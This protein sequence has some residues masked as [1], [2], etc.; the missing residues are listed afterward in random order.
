MLLSCPICASRNLIA[1]DEQHPTA[2]CNDCSVGFQVYLPDDPGELYKHVNYDAH[3]KANA[4]NVLPHSAW[5]RF[6]HDRTVGQLRYNQLEAVLPLEAA[7]DH[8]GWLDFGCGAGGVLDVVRNY[9]YSV[10]GVELDHAFCAEITHHL[11]I[12]T[13]TTSQFLTHPAN[14]PACVLSLFDVLEHLVSPGTWLKVAAECLTH[15]GNGLI[16]LEVPDFGTHVGPISE[17]KHFRPNEHL[18][19]FSSKSL[20]CMRKRYFKNFKLVHEIRPVPGKLQIAW[21]KHRDY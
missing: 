10:R 20:E 3:R 15:A 5:A 17:W 8:C 9:G 7:T 14:Y 6:H 19:A 1:I 13:I 18:Y 16:V 12:R 4:N 2:Q 11:G 21:A